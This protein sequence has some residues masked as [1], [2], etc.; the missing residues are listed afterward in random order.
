[1]G[2][3][4]FLPNAFAQMRI[5]YSFVQKV[6]DRSHNRT[7]IDAEVGY[8]VTPRL[9]VTGIM[10]YAKHHG[11]LDYDSS[12]GL[13]QWTHDELINHDELMR[14]DQLDAGAGAAFLVSKSVSVYANY[15]TIVSGING[16]ALNSGV[17]VGINFRFR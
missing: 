5:N 4:S 6:L 17:I 1:Q 10:S 3:E 2:G 15:L 13:D 16:H 11:G 7:N 8:F 14:S 9:A 12:K